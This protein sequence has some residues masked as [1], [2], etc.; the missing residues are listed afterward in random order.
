MVRY[1]AATQVKRTSPKIT[2]TPSAR[3]NAT[4]RL[5]PIGNWV[6]QYPPHWNSPPPFKTENLALPWFAIPIA[7]G[8]ANR[9]LE[10][11]SGKSPRN[12]KRWPNSPAHL[13]AL[14]SQSA[15]PS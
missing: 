8:M 1:R 10:E 3:I 7:Q 14:A 13:S 5:T 12:L 15:S 11:S 6:C 4:G 2:E 9:S